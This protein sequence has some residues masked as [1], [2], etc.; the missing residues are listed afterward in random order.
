MN[1]VEGNFCV[2][3]VFSTIQLEKS[4]EFA[5]QVLGILDFDLH[6]SCIFML[7]TFCSEGLVAT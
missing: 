2:V 1:R 5:F 4:Y 3:V 6:L 7:R